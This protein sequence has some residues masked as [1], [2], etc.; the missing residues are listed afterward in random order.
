MRGREAAWPR[1]RLPASTRRPPSPRPRPACAGI[2]TDVAYINASIAQVS[3]L[4][5]VDPA[6]VAIQGFSDGATY[7]LTL[8]TAS[9]K[10]FTHVMAFSPG[11]LAPPQLSGNPAIFVSAGLDDAV[12]PYTNS[13]QVACQLVAN[14]YVVD[15]VPFKGGHEVPEKIANAAMQWFLGGPPAGN[16]PAGTCT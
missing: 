13:Q 16:V 1:A 3:D 4:Y 14:Q 6:H 2:G 8:G 11:G 10:T 15:F 7:A 12:F 9:G 5:N